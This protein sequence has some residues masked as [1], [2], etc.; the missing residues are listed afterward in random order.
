MRLTVGGVLGA[1]ELGDFALRP[2]QQ[3]VKALFVPLTLLQRSVGRKAE[4]NVVLIAG[5]PEDAGPVKEALARKAQLEDLAIRVR[6]VS[7]GP[8]R[9]DRRG[10]TLATPWPRAASDAAPGS[11]FRSHGVLVHLANAIRVGERSV[12]YSIVAGL[13]P[14]A[15][16]LGA[17]AAGDRPPTRPQRLD[18]AGAGRA[19]R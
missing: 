9:G 4:A 11:V 3:P 6:P 18:R 16:A 2:R 13:E 15:P 8:R 5:S 1:A 14:D 10:P 7:R 17:A 12:P 19:P